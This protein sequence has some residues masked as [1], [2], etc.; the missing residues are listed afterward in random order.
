MPLYCTEPSVGGIRRSSV[1]PAVVFP[2]PD[3]IDRLHPGDH[4]AKDAPVYGVIL[5][6]VVYFNKW[7]VSITCLFSHSLPLCQKKRNDY[8]RIGAVW[9]SASW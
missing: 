7:L 2:H 1:C 5:Y 6:Q 9:S 8:L 3:V 4:P